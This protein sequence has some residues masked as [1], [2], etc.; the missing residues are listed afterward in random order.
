MEFSSFAYFFFSIEKSVVQFISLQFF[1]TEMPTEMKECSRG[2][3]KL[4]FALHVSE[5]ISNAERIFAVI[6]F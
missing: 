4:L 2:L 6:I 3:I 5:L 1:K